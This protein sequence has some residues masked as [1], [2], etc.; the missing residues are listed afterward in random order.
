MSNH[1]YLEQKLGRVLV[2][3]STVE[4]VVTKEET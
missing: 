2:A 4:W 1:K 3:E